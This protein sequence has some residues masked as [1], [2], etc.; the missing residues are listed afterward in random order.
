[1]EKQL[2][3]W[4]EMKEITPLLT[5]VGETKPVDV[6]WLD[7]SIHE[8]SDDDGDD[9]LEPDILKTKACA[10]K[11]S[12]SSTKSSTKDG[13]EP[14]NRHEERL[15]NPTSASA[16]S[17]FSSETAHSPIPPQIKNLKPEWCC[18]RKAWRPPEKFS[19]AT[20][21]L[22]DVI[23]LAGQG[24]IWFKASQDSY[25]FFLGPSTQAFYII[26]LVPEDLGTYETTQV[27]WTVIG[28]TWATPKALTAAGWPYTEDLVGN[29]WIHKDLNWVCHQLLPSFRPSFRPSFP[30]LKHRKG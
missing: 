23:Q 14:E 2:E 26:S 30:L 3:T 21:T 18:T 12:A 4:K 6:A 22:S 1:L 15:S 27:G 8:D 29:V 19:S 28:K 7:E 20:N 25:E 16:E 5:P 11:G 17:F 10:T 9:E 13:P 24:P